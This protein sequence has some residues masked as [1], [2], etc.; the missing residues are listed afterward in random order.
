V[1]GAADKM[2]DSCEGEGVRTRGR[3]DASMGGVFLL[4]SFLL[5]HVESVV[6]ILFLF[7]FSKIRKAYSS[8]EDR[9]RGE[10]KSGGRWLDEQ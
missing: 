9:R 3:G 10:V 8:L 4:G 1:A 2:S 6:G 5:I 7:L